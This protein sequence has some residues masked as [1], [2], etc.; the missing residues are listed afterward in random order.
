[1]SVNVHFWKNGA[2]RVA[3]FRIQPLGRLTNF[4]VPQHLVDRYRDFKVLNPS[5]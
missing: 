5:T 3:E 2:K 4:D 1:M